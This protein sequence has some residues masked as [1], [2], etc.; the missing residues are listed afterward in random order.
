MKF[1]FATNL[2]NKT[3]ARALKRAQASYRLVSYFE[4][5]KT[6]K[7]QVKAYVCEGEVIS[8]KKTKKGD[9]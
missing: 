3:A 7:K 1:V 9:S 8:R 4:A 2:S 6:T 5:H